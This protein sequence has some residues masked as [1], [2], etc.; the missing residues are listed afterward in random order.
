MAVSDPEAVPVVAKKVKA[1][2]KDVTTLI[3]IFGV[4]TNAL[5]D[6][7]LY[8]KGK[9]YIIYESDSD[10][11]DSEKIP[12]GEDIHEYFLRE[13][14]PYAEDAWINLPAT[15]IGCEISFNKYFYEPKPLRSLEE[16]EADIVALDSKSQGLIRSLLNLAD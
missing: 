9:E 12:V 6:Y 10:L 7:G 13:V 5:A 2:S 11:R 14:K 16:N 8:A 15:K 1:T 3:D 4:D